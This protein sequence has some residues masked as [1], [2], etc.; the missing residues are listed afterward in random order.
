RRW[1]VEPVHWVTSGLTTSAAAWLGSIPLVAYYF[2]LFTP[3][4]LL[5]NLI[6]V[7]LS[8]AALACNLASLAVG[9]WVPGCAELLNHAAWFFMRGMIQ[10][11]ESMA[12]WPGGCFH[13]GTPSLLGFA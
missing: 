7:P 11:S 3:V 8:S 6:V 1:L 4:S 2:H 13:V 5:A 9:G 12:A 10:V